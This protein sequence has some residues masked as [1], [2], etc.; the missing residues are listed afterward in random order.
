MGVSLQHLPV[1]TRDG[2]P[3]INTYHRQE[4]PPRGLLVCLP[5]Q[6]YGVD[7][8]LLYYTNRLWQDRGWDTL[9]LTYSF[10]ATMAELSAETLAA[11]MAEAKALVRAGRAAR[12]HPRGR[13]LGEA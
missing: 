2:L 9:G 7:G 3:V 13:Q 8:P 5:G 6:R 12:A 10:Q 1:A 11:C 4:A